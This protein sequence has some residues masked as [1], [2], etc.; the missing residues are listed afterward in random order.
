LTPNQL[1]QLFA[2]CDTDCSNQISEKEFVDGYE[3]LVETLAERSVSS[4][5]VSP[6][7][8]FGRTPPPAT[9]PH[10]TRT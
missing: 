2:Y 5:G 7:Q 6:M 8:P 3:K 10:A 1:E 4:A 9:P